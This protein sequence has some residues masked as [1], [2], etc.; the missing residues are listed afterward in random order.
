MMSGTNFFS[1]LVGPVKPHVELPSSQEDGLEM[2]VEEMWLDEEERVDESAERED[3][4][5]KP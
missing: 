4:E 1:E 2:E 3:R 5:W